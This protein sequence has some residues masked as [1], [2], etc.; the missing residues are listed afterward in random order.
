MLFGAAILIAHEL[1]G[2]AAEAEL[3]EPAVL[4]VAVTT[5]FGALLGPL[6]GRLRGR[7][8]RSSG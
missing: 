2:D 6:G 5:V 8:Q 7:A 1:S 4:L 3:P